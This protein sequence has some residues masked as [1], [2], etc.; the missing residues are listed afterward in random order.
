MPFLLQA[1]KYHIISRGLKVQ[2]FHGLRVN[3]KT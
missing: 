3:K 1:M 2:V